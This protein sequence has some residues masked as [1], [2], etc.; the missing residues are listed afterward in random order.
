[1]QSNKSEVIEKLRIANNLDYTVN[2]SLSAVKEA[3]WSRQPFN[4]GDVGS[5]TSGKSV[6]RIIHTNGDYIDMAKSYLHFNVKLIG[7]V[8]P[9]S[10]NYEE[11]LCCFGNNGSA[12]NLIKEIEIKSKDG[13]I[14]EHLRA[15]DL[16]NNT[17]LK[18]SKTEDYVEHEGSAFLCHPSRD[19][20]ID[21]AAVAGAGPTA[22]FKTTWTNDRVTDRIATAGG[23]TV[24]IPLSIICG[25]AKTKVL[26]PD[27]LLSGLSFNVVF[28]DFNKVF[29]RK[30]AFLDATY[31]DRDYEITELY[32]RMAHFTLTDAMSARLAQIAKSEGGLKVLFDTYYHQQ[33]DGKQEMTVNVRKNIAQAL[34]LTAKTRNVADINKEDKEEQNSAPFGNLQYQFFHGSRP[35]PLERIKNNTEAYMQA[36]RAFD[37]A[38]EVSSDCAVTSAE[39]GGNYGV[40]SY[41][42]RRS[43][44]MSLSGVA[45]SNASTLSYEVTHPN[46]TE[47]RV[48]LYLEHSV[49]LTV[50]TG[51]VIVES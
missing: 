35:F 14:V 49:L 15:V 17:R 34:T 41:N 16:I 28:N 19:R 37:G 50:Y 46:A 2:R 10:A 13:Q 7:T 4:V 9:K 45:L 42:W 32:L 18:Y 5:V 6:E 43:Q 29:Y 11:D 21:L 8:P 47:R 3:N 1:M 40:A 26:M 39:F 44:D 22:G 20:D 30:G 12:L 24:C 51:N 38:R 36:I 27:Q 33:Q 25:L 31:P 48:D 23:I